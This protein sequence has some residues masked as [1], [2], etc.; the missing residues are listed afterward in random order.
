M[1]Q[2][3]TRRLLFSFLVLLSYVIF[4][5][6]IAQQYKKQIGGIGTSTGFNTVNKKIQMI[7][8]AA[9]L[10]T[11]VTGV[12]DKIYFRKSS[13]TPATV[14]LSDLQ[15]KLGYTQT[16]TFTGSGTTFYTNLSP[17]L[18]SASQ[19]VTGSTANTFF[20]IDVA[21]QFTLPTGTGLVIEVTSSNSS[22]NSFSVLA[23][24]GPAAPSNKALIATDANATTGTAST[25]WLDFGFDFASS[26]AIP[27][28]ND[29]VNATFQNIGSNCTPF[30]GNTVGSSQSL[31]AVT[32]GGATSSV[33]NDVWYSFTAVGADDS[34]AVVGLG[35]F[36]PVIE[37]F[38]GFCTT[39]LTSLACS[40]DPV[41]G[42]ATEILAP[43]NLIQGQ[44]YF[45]RIYGWNG[46]GGSFNACLKSNS[47]AAPVNDNCSA[48]TQLLPFSSCIGNAGNTFG[49]T[50][51]LAPQPC[52]T[53]TSSF[54][55][56]AWYSFVATSPGDSVIVA[57]SGG[58]DPV[59]EIFSGTCAGLTELA[60]SDNP[61]NAQATEKVAPGTLTAGTT[62][63]VR[64]Y[65][66]NGSEGNFNI[67]VKSMPSVAIA[68]NECTGA[69]SLS[70]STTCSSTLGNS[71]GATQSLA[72][73]TCLGGTSSA[74]NDV[75]FKFVATS[76]GDSV[77]VSRVLAFDPVLEMFSGTC[78]GLVSLGCSDQ[79]SSTAIEKLAPGTLVAGVTYYIRVYGWAGTTGQ[80]NICVK[81]MAA[82]TVANDECSGAITLT[83]S[84]V[85]NSTLGNSTGAIQSFPPS[86]CGGVT[87]T[88]AKDVCIPIG[89][90]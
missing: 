40:D 34:I 17:V 37:L 64:V 35:G 59:L 49:A 6:V 53:S 12:V 47:I 41:S 39:G 52:G 58:F 72:P 78:T 81:S 3:T 68:N 88:G 4:N 21:Q 18:Y 61:N 48:P 30:L 33:A 20:V 51:D 29:C 9:D 28:N 85:C 83:G 32:C 90:I 42:F 76:P 19:V 69:S 38:S 79:A 80:F 50:E 13:A 27:L 82:T 44:Q 46:I 55:N 16:N 7:Y 66:F 25:T 8:S 24:T 57:P 10:G 45:F 23:S 11:P 63:I 74:A 89:D 26:L 71:A 75:W 60:C 43:G 15:I 14:T 31:A 73:A 67:C 65:G 70:V 62:Y 2:S 84:T 22:S 54:A 1:H 87:S 77:V 5:P 36:D 86:L 56:D